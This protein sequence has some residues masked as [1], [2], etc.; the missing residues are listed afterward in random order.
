MGWH[1]LTDATEFV[2]RVRV[3]NQEMGVG[4]HEFKSDS[5]RPEEPGG[6]TR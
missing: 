1:M 4:M 2:G 6:D 5:V 3:T